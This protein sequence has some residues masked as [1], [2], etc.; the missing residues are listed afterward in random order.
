M[1]VLSNISRFLVGFVFIF[2]SFVKGVD[3]LGTAYRI[4]DYFIAYGIEW[5][6]PLSLVLSIILCAVEFSVGIALIF[7]LW[8]KFMSWILL[9]MMGYFTMLTLYD[10][11]YEPVPDCG[12]FG[13]A[14]KL[15][16]WATFYKNV[17]LDLFAVIIFIYRKKFRNPV[18]IGLQYLL[19]TLFVLGFIGF[20]WYQYNHLPFLDFRPYKVGTDLK[21][22]GHAEIKTYLI[23]KNKAT[24]ETKEYP[25]SNYPWNDSVWLSQWEFVDQ[26]ADESGVTKTNNLAIQDLEGNDMTHYFLTNPGY[27]F[28]FVSY[29]LTAAN[30]DAFKKIDK[31]FSDINHDGHSLIVLTSSLPETIEEF[32]KG[33]NPDLEFYLVDDTELKTMIR[34]NPGLIL[35]HNGIV[36]KNWHYND[37]PD[38]KQI[39]DRYLN[40]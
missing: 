6:I 34:S 13:D 33:L 11:I 17:V 24:G 5:A 18:G 29:D 40:R 20:S 26:R 27:Q 35:L 16:N 9:L 3:P 28:F 1:K 25:A 7:N 19:L 8:L 21:P 32:R 31:L 2:S 15:S 22:S 23:Y 37:F 12:C 30:K 38:Y 4:E 10:A 39:K 14:L 36:V